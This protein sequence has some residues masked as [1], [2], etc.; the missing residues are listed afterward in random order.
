MKILL[1]EKIKKLG[2]I[3]D[4]VSVKDGYARNYLF[5]KKKAVRFSKENKEKF[6]IEREVIEKLNKEKKATAISDSQKIHG[7][8]ITIVRQAADDGRLYGSV[9]NKDIAKSI[10]E[11]FNVKIFAQDVVLPDKIKEV[12]LHDFSIHLHSDVQADMKV[13][14]S[15][16][17]EE[18]IV[19]ISKENLIIKDTKHNDLKAEQE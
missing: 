8:V 13:V 15:R 6:E 10:E 12:G 1:L 14:V 17:E 19:K 3:G 18:A 16:S 11:T 9:S 5:P 4:F 7:K 2:N